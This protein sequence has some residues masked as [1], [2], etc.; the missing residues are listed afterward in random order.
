ME[1]KAPK[2]SYSA[3]TADK[4]VIRFPEGLHGPLESAARSSYRSMNSEITARLERSL[5]S[6]DDS[7]AHPVDAAALSFD[8][9]RLIIIFRHLMLSRRQALLTL[10]DVDLSFE[11]NPVWFRPDLNQFD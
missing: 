10:L 7:N 11:I 8:E 3:R 9:R 4:F 6:T 2:R 5:A 1:V